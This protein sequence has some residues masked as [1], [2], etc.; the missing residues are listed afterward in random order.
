[1]CKVRMIRTEP[2][3][4]SIPLEKAVYCENCKMVSSSALIQSSLARRLIRQSKDSQRVRRFTDIEA[5]RP[6]GRGRDRFRS[7][8]YHL[9]RACESSAPKGAGVLHDSSAFRRL[10]AQP[11]LRVPKP[12]A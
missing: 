6:P 4:V 10:V 12:D 9:R 7:A 3:L 1:M 8:T 2:G 5:E 11:V